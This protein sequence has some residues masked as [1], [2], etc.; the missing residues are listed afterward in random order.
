MCGKLVAVAGESRTC[1]VTEHNLEVDP[2]LVNHVR[3]QCGQVGFEHGGYFDLQQVREGVGQLDGSGEMRLRGLMNGRAG[4]FVVWLPRVQ[5]A[6]PCWH[7]CD[8][9]LQHQPKSLR[10]HVTPS[11]DLQPSF[12]TLGN[13]LCGKT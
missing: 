10:A 9:L 11:S 7:T 4:G 12:R 1:R 13:L 2:A 5:C 8:H 3:A 6:S